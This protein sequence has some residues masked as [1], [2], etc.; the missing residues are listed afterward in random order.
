[1]RLFHHIFQRITLSR[2]IL[3][4]DMLIIGALAL[5]TGILFTATAAMTVMGESAIR[6]A[7]GFNEKIVES[8]EL[9]IRLDSVQRW[10]SA[11]DEVFRLVAVP[12]NS[13]HLKFLDFYREK[14]IHIRPELEKFALAPGKEHLNTFNYLTDTAFQ[15]G[16]SM[17]A[18]AGAKDS[19]NM[20]AI[21]AQYNRL[22][23]IQATNL[24]SH[25]I[26]RSSLTVLHKEI[27]KDEF[28]SIG[29][30]RSWL[31]S[32]TILAGVVLFLLVKG[33]IRIIRRI[34][35][36]RRAYAKLLE[37]QTKATEFA[38]NL[39]NIAPI[40]YHS[41]DA[42]GIVIDINQTELDWLG[43]TREEVAGKKHITSLTD[44]GTDEQIMA[45]FEA[46]KK[47]GYLL[48]FEAN[49]IA[50]DGHI[51]PTLVNSK[52]V[53]DASGKF[54]HS[55]TMSYNF[56]ERKH[57]ERELIKA[58]E[59]AEA[60][61]RL[62]RLFMANMSH[63]IRTPL[64]AILGFTELLAKTGLMGNQQ[65]YVRNIQIS[66]S[67]L[68]NI[69]NDILDF[70]KM[71]S[72]MMVID[73]VE[74]DLKGLVHSVFT[75]MKTSAVEK[76][77]DMQL[78][79]DSGLPSVLIG[80][81]MRLT[82]I[83]V[84]LLGNAIKF[85][86]NGYVTLHVKEIADRSTEEFRCIRFEVEDSGIGIPESVHEKIF[87]RFTQA[88]ND[89]TRRY[90]GTGLGLSLVKMLTEMQ[91]GAVGLK[92]KVGQ[93]S[94]F[95]IEI[96]FRRSKK[97]TVQGYLME[98]VQPELH[99]FSGYHVLLVEDNQLNRRIAELYL[100][101]MGIAVTQAYNGKHA[102]ELI[103]ENTDGFDLVLM[104]IQMPEMDGYQATTV[105]RKELALTSIPIVAMTAHV[106]SGER[107]NVL[108]AGMNDYLPKPIIH[109]DLTNLLAAYL[110]VSW[111]QGM[112]HHYTNGNP[113]TMQEIATLFVRQLPEGIKALETALRSSNSE[114]IASRAHH[115]R[116]SVDYMGFKQTLGENL[117]KMEQE[118]SKIHPD[119]K[120]LA[121][122]H[123]KLNRDAR[124]AIAIIQEQIQTL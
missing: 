109:S 63:E 112:L 1:M 104:D 78:K 47:S 122:L 116:A 82:Q 36:D 86:E 124:K 60:A 102:V 13:N 120:L 40:G 99:D 24:L 81:P 56:T 34:L 29:H 72:G 35:K 11:Y 83:L 43:Y 96:P 103:Q 20:S 100:V 85:T 28:F 117:L 37:S 68:L 69:V 73:Q 79:K 41:V 77:L 15:L 123:H 12:E 95:T 70:E 61:T 33:M 111:D 18:V 32:V 87:D 16:K 6:R 97:E 115:L 21:L 27:I 57:L 50:K 67:N 98:A 75:M 22:E 48:N 71:H 14:I 65:E 64:N 3:S 39:I 105:I 89:I 93:G 49:L 76:N 45:Q 84:N 119:M 26:L 101:E 46:Y 114:A 108:A 10:V 106:L 74:F 44:Q 90:G 7:I 107:E 94:T 88:S 8:D 25:R 38:R 17:V 121:R 53:Y 80:D 118:A 59:E 30:F 31:Y 52:G 91:Q 92:S 23:L 19:A 4:R 113:Q 66:G 2:P 55:I 9:G 110:K 54:S 42:S 62:K 5:F 58:R 51:I